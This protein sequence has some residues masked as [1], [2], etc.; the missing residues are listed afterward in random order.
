MAAI[1]FPSAPL[2]NQVFAANNGVSYIWNGSIWIT[3]SSGAAQA[4]DTPPSNPVVNQLWFNSALGQLFIYYNDGSSS[5]WVPANP[6][7]VAAPIGGW[8]TLFSQ[9]VAGVNAVSFSPIPST[10]NHLDLR[11]HC[12]APS[13]TTLAFQCY[14]GGTL[15]TASSYYALFSVFDNTP[16]VVT[17]NQGT[18]PFFPFGGNLHA[19]YAAS[20][21]MFMPGI[22][23]T[24]EIHCDL[25][26]QSVDATTT[27]RSLVNRLGSLGGG[28][29]TGL[30][31]FLSSGTFTSG[32]FS[33]YGGT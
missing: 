8:S 6:A 21:R 12:F 7:P 11:Y 32:R 10:I 5:Q 2:L 17:V 30:N 33:L 26:I 15:V 29:V 14:V 19:S 20:G 13:A 3:V 28:P 24:G 25:T 23:T 1:D 4:S 31:I 9:N 16:S 18:N 22:Q 27:K